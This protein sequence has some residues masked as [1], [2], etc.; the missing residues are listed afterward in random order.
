MRPKRL[1]KKLR[2]QY[3]QD[4]LEELRRTRVSDRTVDGTYHPEPFPQEFYECT[5]YAE[6]K[7]MLG[8]DRNF[9]YDVGFRCLHTGES[10][11]HLI[12]IGVDNDD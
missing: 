4:M 1:T 12:E 10:R 3:E 5:D 2:Q 6:E 9:Y 7:D 11:E 8:A